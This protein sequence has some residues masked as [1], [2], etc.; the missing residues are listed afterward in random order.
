MK[1]ADELFPSI[2]SP[3]CF[4]TIRTMLLMIHVVAREN[5]L[6]VL[7]AAMCPKI[8]SPSCQFFI[9]RC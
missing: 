1:D 9:F 2:E 7:L 4:G 8:D 3:N 6:S 5:L